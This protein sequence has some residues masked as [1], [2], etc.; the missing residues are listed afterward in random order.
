MEK[1]NSGFKSPILVQS[2]EN[3]SGLAKSGRIASDKDLFKFNIKG[4]YNAF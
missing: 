1:N 3:L 4:I 2:N